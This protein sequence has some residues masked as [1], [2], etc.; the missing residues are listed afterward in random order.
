MSEWEL[1]KENAAPLAR[2]RNA[3][4][5]SIALKCATSGT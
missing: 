5:L 1:L 4:Q 3:S 2:G